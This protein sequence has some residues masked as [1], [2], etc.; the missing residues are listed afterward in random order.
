MQQVA[1][2]GLQSQNIACFIGKLLAE[3]RDQ[4]MTSLMS[5]NFIDLSTPLRAISHIFVFGLLRIQRFVKLLLLSQPFLLDSKI[6][7]VDFRMVPCRCANEMR[8]PSRLTRTCTKWPK[9]TSGRM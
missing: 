1:F 3:R 4:M 9:Q 6:P 2:D 8:K 5:T 7:L